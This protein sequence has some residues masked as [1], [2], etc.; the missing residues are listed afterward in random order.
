MTASKSSRGRG[1]RC[2]R[3]SLGIVYTI[4]WLL[5]VQLGRRA[6]TIVWRVNFDLRNRLLVLLLALLL[7]LLL[8]S[9][10]LVLAN[11]LL[12]NLQS[13]CLLRLMLELNLLELVYMLEL[14]HS[15]LLHETAALCPVLVLRVVVILGVAARV[16]SIH[17]Q[18]RTHRGSSRVSSLLHL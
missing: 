4:R 1:V 16:I 3:W 17:S 2:C 18:S 6:G 7:L 12:A 8:L 9:L 14:L 10:G 13:R 15:E 5:K 11:L